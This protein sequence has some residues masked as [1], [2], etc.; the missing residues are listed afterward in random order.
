LGVLG[1][2][3]E[4][5]ASVLLEIEDEETPLGAMNTMMACNCKIYWW[6][7]LAIIAAITGKTAYDEK[8][9]KGI[10]AQNDSED[11]DDEE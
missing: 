4:D 10:F 9:K 6:W 8:N 3:D 1:D 11:E 7:L 2:E 5:N